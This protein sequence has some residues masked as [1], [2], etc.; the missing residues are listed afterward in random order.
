MIQYPN[1]AE[2]DPNLLFLIYKKLYDT[3]DFIRFR[4]VCKDWCAAAPLSEH[5]P[6]FPLLLEGDPNPLLS[7]E[8]KVY[9]LSTGKTHSLQLPEAQNKMFFGQSQGYLVTFGIGDDSTPVLLNP[10]TRAEM[11]LPF[12]KCNY[13][14]PVYIYTDPIQNPDGLLIHLRC[15]EK[16]HS[17]AFWNKEDKNWR[18]ARTKADS[19]GVYHKGKLF[20]CCDV[21][22]VAINLNTGGKLLQVPRSNQMRPFYCLIDAGSALLGIVQH[23]L[24]TDGMSLENC[25]FDVYRLEEEEE[26]PRWVKLSDI[27]DLMIFLNSNNGFCLSADDFDGIRGNCIYFTKWYAK[28]DNNYRTLIGRYEL[29]EK[30]S[31]VVGHS[32]HSCGTWI[33]PN[34]YQ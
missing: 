6:Q 32:R 22:T 30:R 1:W 9:S 34:V 19:E 33:V 26:P 10:F 23:H 11:L 7:S 14:S 3:F 25:W 8:F 29:G 15:P 20:I 16:G 2:L 12:K 27:G 31:E 13:F 21:G 28:Y 4:A 24:C 18:F 5:P 17:L